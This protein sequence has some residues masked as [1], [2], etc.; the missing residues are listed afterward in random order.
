MKIV[1]FGD[2]FILGITPNHKEWP[3]T[4][5]GMISQKLNADV[6]FRGQ[7]GTGPWSAYFDFLDY[8]EH[9][10][11]AIFAWSEPGR[12]YHPVVK[13]LNFATV[14]NDIHNKNHP[15]YDVIKAADLYYQHLM[16]NN[17]KNH[18]L[19]ALMTLVDTLSLEYPNTKFIHLPCFTWD[20]DDEWWGDIYEHTNQ[21]QLNYHHTF[22]NGI[23]IHPA[24]MY[25]SI[26]HEWVGREGSHTKLNQETRQCH[27]SVPVH[28]LLADA[29]V[30]GI[31]N[32][33]P[34]NIIN[35][36][37]SPFDKR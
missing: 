31:Q 5:Q 12:M 13:P 11:V 27:L 17:K 34:G 23:Q 3:E 4:Y 37:L 36:D 10:D 8:K 15:H 33:V 6:E 19:K 29:I 1:G 21:D 35:I 28:K 20:K 25:M 22:K 14:R 32:Y 26:K 18:E 24:L 2:S 7:P 9:I 30:D 16:N